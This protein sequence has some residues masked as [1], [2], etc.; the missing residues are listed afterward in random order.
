MR[1]TIHKAKEILGAD[2]ASIIDLMQFIIF[3]RTH[4]TDVLNKSTY[5]Y[6][7][8]FVEEARAR[9]L[10]YQEL[11]HCSDA[12]AFGEIPAKGIIAERIRGN[13]LVFES[14]RLT[15]TIGEKAD[16]IRKI[17]SEDYGDIQEVRGTIASRGV[18]TGT[19]RI[20][21]G[22]ADF[23]K[24][25]SGNIL[26]TS[27]T[28]PEMVA[29]MNKAAAFVTDEGGITCHAAIIS[30]ELNKPCIIGTKN[31]TQILKDGMSVEVDAERGVVRILK[32]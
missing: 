30:R 20:I 7:D 23:S 9:G 18:V 22:R 10:S 26:V 29:I 6:Y 28:T 15:C 8:R 27:M 5:L 31:A 3:Y 19:V 25:E 1:D 2:Q 16:E 12:E 11:L 24:I 21:R 4:R 17:F 32:K 13:V 14:G